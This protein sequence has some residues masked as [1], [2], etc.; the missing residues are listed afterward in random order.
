[1]G[2]PNWNGGTIIELAGLFLD[3]RDDRIAA[4]AGIGAPHAGG[5]VDQLAAVGVT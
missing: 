1:M 3:R 2:W 5:G 4:V